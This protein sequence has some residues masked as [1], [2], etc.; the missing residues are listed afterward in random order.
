VP[1]CACGSHVLV[2]HLLSMMVWLYCK[3]RIMAAAPK[4]LAATAPLAAFWQE[5]CVYQR[6]TVKRHALGCNICSENKFQQRSSQQEAGTAACWA[7]SVA[8]N[9]HLPSS[10]CCLLPPLCFALGSHPASPKLLKVRTPTKNT[11]KP[12]AQL[13]VSRCTAVCWCLLGRGISAANGLAFYLYACDIPLPA[14]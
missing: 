11:R 6:A 13:A 7:L 9:C 14:Q 10:S 12:Q 5:T 4:A 1:E 2:Q 8:P 3:V